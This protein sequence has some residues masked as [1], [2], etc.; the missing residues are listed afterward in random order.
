M[1]GGKRSD[2]YTELQISFFDDSETLDMHHVHRVHRV[3]H[4]SPF[5][6]CI[7]S[8]CKHNF[9]YARI[10]ITFTLH[11]SSLPSASVQRTFSRLLRYRCSRYHSHFLHHFTSPSLLCASSHLFCMFC[12][13]FVIISFDLF[14]CGFCYTPF[15]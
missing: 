8:F 6:A 4:M 10:V 2:S 15:L 7:I 3:H 11:V 5:T 13:L 1:I 12:G 14:W 9:L